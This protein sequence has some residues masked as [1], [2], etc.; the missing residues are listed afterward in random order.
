VE[1]GLRRN[2]CRFADSLKR[3]LTFMTV[4]TNGDDNDQYLFAPAIGR[5]RQIASQDRQNNFEDTDMTNEELGGIRLDD[6]S[7]RR[8]P[9]ETLAGRACFKVTAMAVETDARFPKRITWFD[10]ETF[11]PLQVKVYNRDNT[12]QRVLVAGDIRPVGTIHLP[13]KTVARDLLENHTTILE[14]LDARAD[15][16]LDRSQFDKETMGAVWKE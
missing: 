4:E 15:T 3:G 11:I 8:G 6:Y 12:L 2:L 16:G 10:Q 13:Y 9:D 7:Y 1:S 5:P 14:V